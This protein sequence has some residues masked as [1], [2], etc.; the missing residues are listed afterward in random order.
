VI[1]LVGCGSA[2]T[3][4]PAPA[5][6]LYTGAMFQSGVGYAESRTKNV[7]IVSGKH[8]L[9]SLDHVVE[10]YD[11]KLTRKVAD[12][13]AEGVFRALQNKFGKKNQK[14][15]LVMGDVYARP[16]REN[17]PRGWEALE[18]LKGMRMPGRRINW[19][20]EKTE[21]GR[22]KTNHKT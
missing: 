5:R 9:L 4:H 1:A 17:L 20:R 6:E 19:L 11:Y 22:G 3:D 14:I 16:L 13:W 18:P 12:T 15:L 10:P 7:F 21:A 2:K 8:G